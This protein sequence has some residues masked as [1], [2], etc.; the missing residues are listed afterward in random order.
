MLYL[1]RRDL[2]FE[3]LVV[4]L[5]TVAEAAE[6]IESHPRV[7][8][9]RARDRPPEVSVRPMASERLQPVPVVGREVGGEAETLHW[10]GEKARV[11][12]HKSRMGD[13]NMRSVTRRTSLESAENFL[14]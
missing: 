8:S 11:W 3:L 2:T 9:L 12:R 14:W 1:E 6:V 10:P 4:C 5:T 13:W 7:E